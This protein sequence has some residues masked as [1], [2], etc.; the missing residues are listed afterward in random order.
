[1]LCESHASGS[2]LGAEAGILDAGM[3]AEDR[4]APQTSDEL[5]AKAVE[6]LVFFSD[7]V[8]AIIITLMVLEVRLPHLPEHAGDAAVRSALAALGP[9]YFAVS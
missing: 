7:A 4:K 8:I 3:A 5:D 1:M 9:K 2:D 6:R